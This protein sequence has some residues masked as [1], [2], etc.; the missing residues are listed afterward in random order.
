[1][2]RTHEFTGL[3]EFALHLAERQVAVRAA[4]HRGL[5]RAALLVE[6]E[7]KAE[8][9]HYQDATGPFPAWAPL[10][11]STE[12][13]KA[14][15][16]YPEGAPLLA[17][18]EMRENISHEIDGNE[19]AIGS[20]DEK[21]VY[22]EFGTSK[23]PPRPVFGPA[24]FRNQERIQRILGAALVSGLIDGEVNEGGGDYFLGN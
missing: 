3:A 6:R 1:M 9:G 8:I 20:P 15:K 4:A 7:A 23:M 5:K 11:Q 19:A 22:H 24:V 13:S 2:N 17:T 21:M 12:A 16:G 10:A 14:A 18:G